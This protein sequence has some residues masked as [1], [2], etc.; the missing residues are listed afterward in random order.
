MVV[1][2]LLRSFV[3][4]EDSEIITQLG[5]ISE[6]HCYQKGERLYEIGDV[7]SKVYLLMDGILRCYMMD[8]TRAEITDCFMSGQWIAAN[9]ADFFL[10]G[11]E[12]PSFVGTEALT[13]AKVLEI[14][15]KPLFEML[16]QYPQLMKMYVWCLERALN[17]QNEINYKRLYLSGSKRYEWFCE[18]WPEVD[19]IASNRQI[20]SFLGIRS[21]YL[22]RLR[23]PKK[24]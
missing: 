13:E 20:A 2:E 21:E 8:N 19:K 18:R 1:E 5:S 15:A 4:T 23:H 6:I 17:F 24:K 10:K 14:S 12:T 9:S 22:S 11:N 16:Q 7:Q 3:Q